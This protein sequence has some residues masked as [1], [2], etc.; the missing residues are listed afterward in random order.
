MHDETSLSFANIV[1][2]CGYCKLTFFF[3]VSRPSRSISPLRIL[4]V[5][6]GEQSSEGTMLIVII[7]SALSPLCLR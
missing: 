4:V 5:E 3:G 6:I 2:A 1:V 7:A